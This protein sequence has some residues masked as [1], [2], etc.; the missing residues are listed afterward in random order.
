MAKAHSCETQYIMEILNDVLAEWK[1]A[2]FIL[3][4][5]LLLFCNALY[6]SKSAP[7]IFIYL[8]KVHIYLIKIVLIG[9]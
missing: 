1:S 3:N 5:C 2:T 9:I 6:E 7:Y 4:I 8:Y